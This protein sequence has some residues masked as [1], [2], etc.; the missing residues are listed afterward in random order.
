MALY[1]EDI[2]DIDLA[3]DRLHRSFL[4]HSIGTGDVAANRFGIRVFRN[5]EEVDLTGCS[6]YGYFRDPMGNNIALTSHGTIDGNLAYITLP[7]ACYN[8]DG[9]FTLAIKLIGGGV[10]GTM[11]IVDGVVDNTNTGGAVA[12]TGTVPTYT[13]VLSQYDAMVAATAAA[14]GCI[15]ETF[16]ATKAYSAGQYVINSGSL[17]RLTADHAANVT[18]AN[19]SKVEVKFGNELSDVNSAINGA[20][21]LVNS[22][23]HLFDYAYGFGGKKTYSSSSASIKV[24]QYGTKIVA[25]GNNGLSGTNI[26][27]KL[28][29]GLAYASSNAAVDSW[30]N[31]V[32]GLKSGHKYKVSLI[33]ISGSVSHEEGAYYPSIAVYKAGGHASILQNTGRG[34]NGIDYS[35]TFVAESGISYHF[36]F[37][38]TS[39]ATATNA[40]YQYI[41]EDTTEKTDDLL[42]T[43]QYAEGSAWA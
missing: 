1:K 28:N 24:L 32:S 4:P 35:G 20:F 22:V 29:G 10:T 40:I 27:F 15:A 2:V 19:T 25:N 43:I 30:A 9:Q 39:L 7:Q 41:V 17:Y 14:N 36:A 38:F 42:G 37:V 33:L 8:Y 31:P 34:E 6:C 5:G 3:K 12:P 18:W 23:D 16:D 21:D 11:R 26:R 13:E